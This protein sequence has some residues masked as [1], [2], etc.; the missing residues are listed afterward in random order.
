MPSLVRLVCDVCAC[1][2]WCCGDMHQLQRMRQATVMQPKG[3]MGLDLMRK[4]SKQAAG[5]R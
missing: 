4:G 5:D 3:E 2:G 1:P